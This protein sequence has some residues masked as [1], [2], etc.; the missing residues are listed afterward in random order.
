MEA[1]A[2]RKCRQYRAACLKFGFTTSPNDVKLPMSYLVFS[3]ESMKPSRLNKYFYTMH[4]NKADKE[5]A[6]FKTQ[7]DLPCRVCLLRDQRCKL[8]VCVLPIW[9][10]LMIAKSGKAHTI[11]EELL[12]PVI[13]EVLS[14][15]LHRPAA[16]T[17][18]SIPL[19]NNTVQR[20]IDD[21]AKDVEETLCN[22]L[23]NTEFSVQL[24][25]S[26]LPGNEALLLAYV[27]FIKE[28]LAEE[29]LFARELVTDN[30]KFHFSGCG[31]VLQRKRNSSYEYYLC[32]NRW[33]SID[34]KVVPHV[35]AIRCVLH[36]QNLVARRLSERLHRSL[37]YL[38]AAVNRIR[39]KSLS[40]SLFRQLCDQNDED[41]HRLL[42]HTEVRWLS[43]GA[44]LTRFYNLFTSLLEFFEKTHLF[45][46]TQRNSKVTLPI[47]QI[48][49]QNSMNLQFQGDAL[50]LIRARSV[51]S[52]FV[53]KL[54]FFRNNLSRGEFYDVPNFCENCYPVTSSNGFMISSISR[55]QEELFELQANEL[56]PKFKLGYATF[57]LQRGV[58]CLYPR[59]WATV[60]KYLISF[61][62]S[63]LVERGFGVVTDL[64]TKKRNRLQVVNRGDL[65]LRLT[66]IEPNVEKL[67]SSRCLQ[68]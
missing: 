28:Q 16:E 67:L 22:F 7:R 48:F 64:L 12:L 36:R 31:R 61:P 44:C 49:T 30:G 43:K 19:S 65:R 27:R 41:F 3:N 17:I 8:T 9:I 18:N 24:D 52:A 57:S 13:S 34:E 39:C 53:S 46:R 50:N 59:L 40:D 51:I 55:S 4:P 62:S 26:T 42:L 66:N 20:R 15:V 14:T 56:K 54:L 33:R 25:E 45:V 23:K 5:L 29:F 1:E 21:M 32:C 6:Y 37:Q 47:W 63:Y 10:S 38:I 60:R 58:R 35:L 68:K 11:G 2:K